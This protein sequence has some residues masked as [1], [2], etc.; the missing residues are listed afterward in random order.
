M[1]HLITQI[2]ETLNL[3]KTDFADLLKVAPATVTRWEKGERMPTGQDE[4]GALLRAAQPEQQREL[5]EALGIDDVTRFAAD[6]LASAGVITGP[7]Y[8]GYQIDVSD[9]EA[10]GLFEAKYGYPPRQVIR[11]DG[12]VLA[13]P[14]E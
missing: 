5:L 6:L 2:R 7:P 3:N 13:G 4:I 10:R 11:N 8:Q 9:D 12:C 1:K 14:I